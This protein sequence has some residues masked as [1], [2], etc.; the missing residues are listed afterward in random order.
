MRTT[1]SH[2][3]GRVPSRFRNER[4]PTEDHALQK[5]CGRFHEAHCFAEALN[6]VRHVAFTMQVPSGYPLCIQRT[7]SCVRCIYKI[8]SDV[9]YTRTR[10]MAF[11]ADRGMFPAWPLQL[12]AEPDHERASARS[13]WQALLTDESRG[14]KNGDGDG[15]GRDYLAIPLVGRSS[16]R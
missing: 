8:D 16:A 9:L 1:Y 4:R 10:I 14:A 3:L 6:L 12:P 7:L 11:E 2:R 13:R 5:N 15:L